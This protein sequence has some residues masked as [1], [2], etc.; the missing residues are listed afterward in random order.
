MF[1]P[2]TTAIAGWSAAIEVRSERFLSFEVGTEPAGA[3][4]TMRQLLDRNGFDPGEKTRYLMTL[5]PLDAVEALAA[6]VG[7]CRIDGSPCPDPLALA[8]ASLSFAGRAVAP[9]EIHPEWRAVAAIVATLRRLFT[10]PR[11]RGG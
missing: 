4:V 1:N 9:V 7:R 3:P 10:P 11:S 2:M 5:P 8:R 6:I